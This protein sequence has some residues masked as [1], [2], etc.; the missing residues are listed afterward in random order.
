MMIAKFVPAA[1][2]PFLYAPCLFI[3]QV[4]VNST[5][6]MEKDCNASEIMMA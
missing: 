1:K 5:G 4:A 2:N 3:L 6:P